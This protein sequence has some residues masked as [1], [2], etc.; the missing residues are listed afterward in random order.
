MLQEQTESKDF[1]KLCSALK[2]Q[3]AM[4]NHYPTGQHAC[5]FYSCYCYQEQKAITVMYL[6]F[7]F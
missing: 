3:G 4:D 5:A 1:A 7:C 2:N 6:A